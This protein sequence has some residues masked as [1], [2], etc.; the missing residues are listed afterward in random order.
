MNNSPLIS[1]ITAS[2][3]AELLLEK[4][5]ISVMDQK[6]PSIE[7]IIIDGGSKDG[8]LRIIDRY[9]NIV[10]YTISEPDAGIYD[11]WN[12]GIKVAKGEW[13]SFLGAGDEYL[14]DAISNYVNYINNLGETLPNF[15]SSVVEVVKPDGSALYTIGTKYEW[16]KYLNYMNVAH[17]GSLHS[18]RLF[19]EYDVYN[20]TYKLVG[21]YEL[22]LRAGPNLRAGFV[23]VITAKMLF[24]GMSISKKSLKE[25][26][27]AK[28]SSGHISVRRAYLKYYFSLFKASIRFF[29]YK[30]G[31]YISIRK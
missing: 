5:I 15:I 14:P 10:K 4:T 30:M 11:A 20:T 23:S 27:E 16:P 1:I 28:L 17:V 13:I 31:I 2:Y 29:L 9:K 24:G 6:Y 3:N 21:D 7:Y 8:T 12:K 25:V 22:L 19:D 18:R 26:F